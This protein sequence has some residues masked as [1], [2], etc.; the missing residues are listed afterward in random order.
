MTSTPQ[1]LA[2][3]NGA[4]LAG[5][6]I[7]NFWSDSEIFFDVFGEE[8]IKVVVKANRTSAIHYLLNHFQ[9]S[10]EEIHN[11]GGAESK[12]EFFSYLK[13]LLIDVDLLPD[14]QEPDFHNCKDEDGHY[15]CECAKRIDEWEEYAKSMASEIDKIVIHSAFQF[16]F[17]DRKFLHDFNLKLA[18]FIK[19]KIDEIKE[20]YPDNVTARG[21]VRRWSF[22]VWLKKA[23]F[24]RDKGKCV[25][26]R[27]DLTGVI[28]LDSTINIDHIV[29]LSLFGTNDASNMQLLCS[30]C[31][32]K[33]SDRNTDTSTTHV[34]FWNIDD[35]FLK[36]GNEW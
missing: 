34:P 35:N 6:T 27:C 33:K 5:W 1:H 36:W 22:P 19:E 9:D 13:R 30:D 10:Y 2:M 32:A 23:V 12:E 3:S 25:I 18:E 31:N 20:K 29:P 14:L 15:E 16:V 4:G 24:H 28:T 7:I 8:I 11:V 21:R 26:C 17:Q